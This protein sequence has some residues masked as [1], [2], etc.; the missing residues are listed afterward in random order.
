MLDEKSAVKAFLRMCVD[1]SDDSITRKRARGNDDE[2]QRWQ[3]YRDFTAY[4][5]KE[6]EDGALDEWFENLQDPSWQPGPE[7]KS[8]ATAADSTSF[9]PALL[10]Y[11]Q[12]TRLLDGLVAPRPVFVAA[13]RSA[14]GVDNLSLLST[15]SVLSNSPPL[16]SISLS[17]DR[18]G[19]PRDTL[20]NLRDDG[21]ITLHLLPASLEGIAVAEAAA[22]VIPADESEWDLIPAEP[23]LLPGAVASLECELLEQ[24]SL[25]QGAVATL[26]ILA[27]KKVRISSTVKEQL[28]NGGRVDTLY[29][30]GWCHLH[31]SDA[32]W[33]HLIH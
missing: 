20:L 32:A 17:Q 22:K 28:L 19:R 26:C 1:Y 4:A 14:S 23:P 27:L 6:I 16:L 15:V 33:S 25:P 11:V 29:Q 9:D 8:A 12:R 30:H 24:H 31:P 13:T 2:V 10:N 18:E 21:R 3:S 7:K 5:I